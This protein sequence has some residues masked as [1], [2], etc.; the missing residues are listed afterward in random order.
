MSPQKNA[1][2]WI[3]AL[4]FCLVATAV[5]LPQTSRADTNGNA[6]EVPPGWDYL[7]WKEDFSHAYVDAEGEPETHA[8]IRHEHDDSPLFSIANGEVYGGFRA[9]LGQLPLVEVQDDTLILRAATETNER[10]LPDE[11]RFGASVRTGIHYG[12]QE[13]SIRAFEPPVRIEIRFRP[14]FRPGNFVALWMMHATWTRGPEDILMGIEYDLMETGG[15]MSADDESGG[16]H[17]VHSAVHS[18]HAYD[19]PEWSHQSGQR[20]TRNTVDFGPEGSWSKA[21]FEWLTGPEDSDK[22]IRYWINDHLLYEVTPADFETDY[23]ENNPPPTGP[24]SWAEIIREMWDEP[25]HLLLWNHFQHAD[26]F[27]GYEDADPDDF[28]VEVTIDWVRTFKK[29]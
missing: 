21:V 14:K 4:L 12:F 24:Y 23:L 16:K 9:Q 3:P 8:H 18:W 10:P 5:L 17:E 25:M 13:E 15:H 26:D 29:E 1:F 27:L 20:Y 28:P 11:A 6:V 19:T 7:D 2:T 22:V